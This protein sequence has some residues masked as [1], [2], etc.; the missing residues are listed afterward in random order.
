MQ[1]VFAT[2]IEFLV[3]LSLLSKY[4]KRPLITTSRGTREAACWKN[5]L[6]VKELHYLT[7]NFSGEDILLHLL[8]LIHLRLKL[9]IQLHEGLSLEVLTYHPNNINKW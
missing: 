7:L 3:L 8:A 9:D 6:R 5:A 1:F 2:G 4:L